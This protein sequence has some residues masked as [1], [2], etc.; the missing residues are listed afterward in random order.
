MKR[1]TSIFAFGLILL[2]GI[3]AETVE[4]N[5]HKTIRMILLL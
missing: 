5:Y 1:N 3:I 2:T 4:G